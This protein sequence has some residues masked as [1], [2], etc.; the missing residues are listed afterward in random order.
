M[1]EAGLASRELV[2]RRYNHRT[3]Q[4]IQTYMRMLPGEVHQNL[5]A[6]ITQASADT[7]ARWEA[8]LNPD[9]EVAN[10][11][12]TPTPTHRTRRRP[13]ANL[14]DDAGDEDAE[15][16]DAPQTKTVH[17]QSTLTGYI[18]MC[19]YEGLLDHH[20]QAEG[21]PHV[22]RLRDIADKEVK[23]SW[24]WALNKNHGPVIPSEEYTD[25]VRIRLGAAGPDE[26]APCARCDNIIDSAGS[27]CLTCAI[28]PATR[29]HNQVARIVHELATIT[30]SSAEREPLGL[31]LSHPTLRPADILTTATASGSTTAL[32][33]GITSP[34]CGTAG[35]DCCQ[36]MYQR[37]RDRYA[38]HI[39]ELERNGIT[40]V[41]IVWSAYGRPHEAAIDAI[42]NMARR[43]A[44]RRGHSDAVTIFNRAMHNIS[45]VI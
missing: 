43:A 20:T 23:H 6:Y 25:A 14:V 10:Q 4:A 16:P 38:P 7:I 5:G 21:W 33:V 19:T 9:A 27:H 22:R 31:T 8:L 29:G 39:T 26:P 42:R 44:R 35:T 37:K 12:D 3:T 1:E 30:D 13:G 15:H 17:I 11:D 45:V 28:G 36:S 18:D 32:D 24:L 40:Y 34:D 41:P 2:M